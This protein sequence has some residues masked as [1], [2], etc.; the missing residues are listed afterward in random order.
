MKPS[1]MQ[2][3]LD[4][5]LAAH[6]YVKKTDDEKMMILRVWLGVFGEYDTELFNKALNN[7]IKTNRFFPAVS[8]I[9]GEI[10]KLTNPDSLI[11]SSESFDMVSRAVQLYGLTYTEIAME[12]LPVV[13]RDA[14]RAFGWHELC[15]GD[16]KFLRNSWCKAWDAKASKEE[17]LSITGGDKT[18]LTWLDVP[19]LR[20]GV[21]K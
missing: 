2:E 11:S 10:V 1:E 18:K 5:A 6:P 9:T 17:Y 12:S 19:D 3:Y 14:V 7:V 13:V 15:R 16:L 20:I 8:V 4:L 21:K